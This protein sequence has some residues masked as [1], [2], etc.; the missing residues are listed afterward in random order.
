MRRF[1]SGRLQI[2]SLLAEVLRTG[3]AEAVHD[4]RVTLRR[5]RLLALVGKPL[6]GK[7]KADAFREWALK[8]A[9][10]LGSVRDCDVIMAWLQDHAPDRRRERLFQS[11]RARIW[12]QI[13]PA[14]AALSRSGG[15][16]FGKWDCHPG[17]SRKLQKRFLKQGSEIQAGL[18][19]DAGRFLQ[20]NAAG[21]HQ[22]RR[23]LRR[24]RYLRELALSQRRQKTDRTLRQL[25]ACQ[26][27]L[28]DIQDCAA[29]RGVFRPGSRIKSPP[30]VAQL[31]QQYE[32]ERLQA[33]PRHL[34]SFMRR[35]VW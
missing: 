33:V 19:S 2:Q 3:Q 25:I 10:S 26:E 23:S 31:A 21:R 24:L 14:L 27:I 17:K 1:R 34:R 22:F 11:Q 15:K 13:R 20:M 28:G 32:Q 35:L 16:Y 6:L 18:R 30:K 8:L 9:N 5:T 4:L 29:V 12:R 7:A